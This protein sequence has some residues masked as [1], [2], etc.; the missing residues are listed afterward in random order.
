LSWPV[1]G[2]PA[3]VAAGG[4]DKQQRRR[5]SKKFMFYDLIASL[6]LRF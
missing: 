1:L 2:C 3:T 6:T 4:K 5:E